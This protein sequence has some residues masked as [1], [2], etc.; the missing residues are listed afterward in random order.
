[1]KIKLKLDL[2]LHP[3][4]G[5]F[6]E[7]VFETIHKADPDPRSVWFIGKSGEECKVFLSEFDIVEDEEISAPPVGCLC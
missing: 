2:P 4:H 5:A 3:R 7:A 1:M 6:K